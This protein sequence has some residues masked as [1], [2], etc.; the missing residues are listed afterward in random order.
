[1]TATSLADVLPIRSA[2]ADA[3]V[4]LLCLPF[5]GGTAAAYREWAALLPRS[6]EVC[7]VELPGHGVRFKEQAVADMD[8]LVDQLLAALRPLFDRRVVMF[9]HSLGARIAFAMARREPR[10]SRLIVSAAP[11]AHLPPRRQRSGLARDAFIQEL[12]R[13]GGT[14]QRIL[15]DPDMMDYFM[16]V[17][18]ADFSL[19]ERCLAPA[20]AK[21]SCPIDALAAHDDTEVPLEHAA[22][23]AELTGGA[24][25]LIEMSG[26]HFYLQSR[27]DAVLAH[28]LNLLSEV[29]AP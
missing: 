16:P 5:S 3:S 1:M 28:V 23:W 18:R 12:A 25:R 4:R 17:L 21:V 10:V 22:A 11:A 26:G 9:G 15:A 8:V 13:L 19:L 14:P 2:Q 7:A 20:G 27:R 29:P 6:I 24:F